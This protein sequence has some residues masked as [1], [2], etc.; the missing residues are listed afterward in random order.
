MLYRRTNGEWVRVASDGQVFT[1]WKGKPWTRDAEL[2][3]KDG[4]KPDPVGTFFR[5]V[6]F[7]DLDYSPEVLM[8]PKA[9]TRY[10]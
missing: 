2:S 9:A 1:S 6:L 8:E 5:Q 7:V 4:A 10:P 3:V